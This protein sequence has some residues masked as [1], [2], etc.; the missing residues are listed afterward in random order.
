MTAPAPRGPFVAVRDTT[1]LCSTFTSEKDNEPKP[2]QGFFVH[3]LGKHRTRSRKG[4]TPAFSMAR[5]AEGASRGN[6]GVV[7]VSALVYDFDHLASAVAELVQRHLE[8]WAHVAYSSYSHFATGDDDCC[9]RAV[10]LCTRPILPDEYPVVWKAMNELLGDWADRQASDPAR[11]WYLPACPSSRRQFAWLHVEDGHL[12]DVDAL[13]EIAGG[14]DGASEPKADHWAEDGTGPAGD[15]AEAR[16]GDRADAP[17]PEGERNAGL[18]SLAGSMRHKGMGGDAILAALRLE[19]E[20]RCVPP[21]GDEELAAIAA[22]VSKY[23]PEAPLLRRHLSDLGNAERLHDYHGSELRYVHKMGAWLYWDGRR[24]SRDDSGETIRR[25]RAMIRELGRLAAQVREKRRR[26]ALQRHALRSESAGK[27]KAMLELGQALLTLP[28]AAL[29]QRAMLF[30][31]ANGTLDLHLGE[32]RPHRRE[33]YLTRLSSVTYDPEAT[34]PIWEAF[35]LRV[36]G[37][38]TELVTFLQRA[39]GYTLSGS[40]RE[41]VLFLLYGVGA[42]GKSTFIEILRLL[43]GEYAAQAEFSTFLKQDNATVRNDIARLAGARFVAAVEAEGGRP[44]A[45]AVVKQM[46]G[47]DMVVARFL[48]Q[49]FFE[50][51]PAFKVWL[52]ANHKPVIKGT[53]HGIWRRI[54]LIPFLVTIPEDERDPDLV[55]KLEAE[56]PGILAWAVRGCLDWQA[57]GLGVPASVREA[58]EGYRDEMDVLGGFLADRCSIE[59]QGQVPTSGLY[60]A[61]KKWA[62]EAGERPITKKAMGLRLAERGFE[63]IKGNRGVRCWRGLHLLPEPQATGTRER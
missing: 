20:R 58:T 54:R 27:I 13:L 7:E 40:T 39:V 55:K 12:L 38:D 43:T 44:L 46:T 17:F 57:H 56:L 32:L 21:L 50:F 6:A 19:N 15:Q 2:Y 45:E 28:H 35:L 11:I 26:E 41:Q 49:N 4:G 33:D 9:F 60:E 61:Y 47:G 8:G 31:C 18:T 14:S 34:C 52:A 5:Y 3:L 48:F 53:D 59:A 62:E 22:S 36:M 30:A 37:D 1:V 63:S 24:W 25:A 23:D 16:G 29:D 10:I 42:N 51:R